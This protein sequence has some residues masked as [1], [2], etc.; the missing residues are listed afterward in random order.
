MKRGHSGLCVGCRSVAWGETGKERACCHPR[1]SGVP[2]GT[3]LSHPPFSAMPC[4]HLLTLHN[5]E[6]PKG[7]AI[8][9]QQTSSCLPTQQELCRAQQ[10]LHMGGC[11]LT[12]WACSLSKLQ[13]QRPHQ[14]PC[15]HVCQGTAIFHVDK[16]VLVT[17]NSCYCFFLLVGAANAVL[18]AAC[19]LFTLPDL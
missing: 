6:A 19:L 15:Q 11:S 7:I 2:W 5:K 4:T 16:Y 10:C 9:T 18:L 12:A 3:T 13:E 17:N 14:A 8:W 1:S